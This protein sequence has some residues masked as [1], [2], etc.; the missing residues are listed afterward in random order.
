MERPVHAPTDKFICEK[1]LL[2]KI[3]KWNSNF[4]KFQLREKKLRR[5][6]GCCY[7][8]IFGN[9]N[10]VII[11]DTCKNCNFNESSQISWKLSQFSFISI[12]DLILF[13]RFSISE[14]AREIEKNS[15]IRNN[16]ERVTNEKNCRNQLNFCSW[17]NIDNEII[18]RISRMV[19]GWK[20]NV[21]SL[22]HIILNTEEFCIF[23]FSRTT[24]TPPTSIRAL[25]FG[26]SGHSMISR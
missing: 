24:P 26:L 2:T 13:W 6:K 10:Y 19:L 23:G 12:D 1:T 15:I 3:L 21:E 7:R 8:R 17:K 11:N 20:L 22:I 4:L 5:K 16:R 9:G 18:V 14:W 25:G